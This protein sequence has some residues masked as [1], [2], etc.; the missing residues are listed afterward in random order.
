MG[1]SSFYGQFSWGKINT[2]TRKK[3]LSFNSYNINGISG[4]STG[5]V[6][7]RINPLRYIGYSTTV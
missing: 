3:P 6:I 1:Y 2:P 5:A 7:Q 4:L